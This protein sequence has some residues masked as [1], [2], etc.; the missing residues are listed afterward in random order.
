M[1]GGDNLIEYIKILPITK[2]SKMTLLSF[3]EKKKL[4]KIPDFC[5]F[6]GLSDGQVKKIKSYV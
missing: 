1:N 5:E 6:L 2:T 4:S 3:I